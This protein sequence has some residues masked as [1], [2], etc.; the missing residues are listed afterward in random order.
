MKKFYIFCLAIC[1]FAVF[2]SAPGQ[3]FDQTAYAKSTQAEKPEFKSLLAKAEK[4][5]IDAQ[6]KVGLKYALGKDTS[7]DIEKAA[8]WYEKA[9]EKGHPIAQNNLGDLYIKGKDKKGK[10]IKQDVKKGLALMAK[11]PRSRNPL[12]LL[13]STTWLPIIKLVL[14]F[15][16]TWIKPS[17][18]IPSLRNLVMKWQYLHWGCCIT[19]VWTCPRMMRKQRTGSP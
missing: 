13:L 15:P 16:G 18:I 7:Q 19:K 5:N 3:N 14:V 11:A 4:G 10:G 8:Q 2:D 1:C 12:L 9:A 6:F 17:G